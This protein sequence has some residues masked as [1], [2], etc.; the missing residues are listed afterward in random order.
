MASAKKKRH[1]QSIGFGSINRSSSRSAPGSRSI[2]DVSVFEDMDVNDEAAADDREH[3]QHD[4][5]IVHLRRSTAIDTLVSRELACPKNG[6]AT[7][8]SL[9]TP[10]RATSMAEKRP[11]SAE[12]SP[13]RNLKRTNVQQPVTYAPQFGIAGLPRHRGKTIPRRDITASMILDHD[14]NE[15]DGDMLE[16][17][18]TDT[19]DSREARVRGLGSV[20]SQIQEAI[21]QPG[22]A[23]NKAVR[24]ISK[25][26]L[27][28]KKTAF[29]R[30][31]ALLKALIYRVFELFNPS[32]PL[33]LFGVL[34]VASFM[35]S[36][37]KDKIPAGFQDPAKRIAELEKE[38]TRLLEKIEDMRE[39]RVLDVDRIRKEKTRAEAKASRH[40]PE[41]SSA[42]TI[43]DSIIAKYKL[44]SFLFCD[45]KILLRGM[46]ELPW[47]CLNI[48]CA[49]VFT[50]ASI[51][52]VSFE[53]HGF[54]ITLK[55][56][57][58]DCKTL[59]HRSNWNRILP[60]SMPTAMHF[61]AVLFAGSSHTKLQRSLAL[62]GVTNQQG[63]TA[64]YASRHKFKLDSVLAELEAA[65]MI[66][67]RYAFA[68]WCMSK[69]WS[70]LPV[71]NDTAWRKRRNAG[72]ADCYLLEGVKLPGEEHYGVLGHKS[73]NIGRSLTLKDGTTST[74]LLGT[75]EGASG[76]MEYAMVKQFV[77]DVDLNDF[78]TFRKMM[79]EWTCDGDLKNLDL[80]RMWR[81]MKL[82][83]KDHSHDAKV[84]EKRLRLPKY[85]QFK[86]LIPEIMKLFTRLI[87]T[88][89]S[90]WFISHGLPEK[91]TIP[92]ELIEEIG[93]FN[94][95][96]L[97]KQ[98]TGV[99]VKHFQ[100]DHSECLAAACPGKTADIPT[101][102]GPS[103]VGK[104]AKFIQDFSEMLV[105]VMKVEAGQNR[106]NGTTSSS[107]E[108]LHHSGLKF[109]SKHTDTWSTGLMRSQLGVL[110]NNDG[111]MFTFSK[112]REACGHPLAENDN[113]WIQQNAVVVAAGK[114]ATYNLSKMEEKSLARKE[115]VAMRR[116]E[117]AGI[118]GDA[119]WV[120]YKSSSQDGALFRAKK[121]HWSQADFQS[122]L[123][124]L[125]CGGFV[126]QGVTGC[127]HL[128]EFY[129]MQFLKYHPECTR[130]D[131]MGMDGMDV[132]CDIG[133]H[134]TTEE[135]LVMCRNVV[136][137]YDSWKP[138]M[139]LGKVAA[140]PDLVNRSIFFGTD[141]VPL[142]PP[143][144]PLPT[145]KQIQSNLGLNV[146]TEINKRPSIFFAMDEAQLNPQPRRVKGI[147][148][149]TVAA[150]IGDDH[151][152]HLIL[153]NEP[154]KWTV[155]HVV[156]W[157]TDWVLM[158]RADGSLVEFMKD[159]R[160]N[161]AALL[162]EHLKPPI[163]HVGHQ[164]NFAAS[165]QELRVMDE[166]AVP[167]PVYE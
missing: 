68:E 69:N 72:A 70:F 109:L 165:I 28:L 90:Y 49:K 162:S 66:A 46:I 26:L 125:V 17:S 94:E 76:L 134:V 80:L 144:Q 62:M 100:N 51:K 149:A 158:N 139:R 135:D 79:L 12:E 34:S 130:D 22:D 118:D 155:E 52:K 148:T 152:G 38:N 78:L 6:N 140:G 58:P 105:Y 3:D 2:N 124:C 44:G 102:V 82:I 91:A 37:F 35:N 110:V 164:L 154:S 47:T 121:W 98:L 27:A 16:P 117:M 19:P 36:H 54:D 151:N 1:N 45:T 9:T 156:Q 159:E 30:V 99:A 42:S 138:G 41:V 84:V 153:H 115:F 145:K 93:T 55:C 61:S 160:I 59:L 15:S 63:E 24:T 5:G 132:I 75:H 77:D 20:L 127:C 142:N 128:C 18:S 143:P 53:V 87:Y 97:H 129:V 101:L 56:S 92:V 71:T 113:D 88:G 146:P 89:K 81:V 147:A 106:I 39:K 163:S 111:F 119:S 150:A 7:P 67:R 14:G 83:F 137:Q 21:L 107:N 8:A 86:E 116:D 74:T 25:D 157:T 48:D 96:D 95:A 108:A 103:L 133:L 136:F 4:Q 126:R 60:F 166:M 112:L 114:H 13:S 29:N 73:V 31:F 40:I 57:C 64:F 50:I 10:A 11:F 32:D 122:V 85:E 23:P 167:P 43:A 104:N 141:E 33:A 120:M 123:M 161:G 131:V 65:S